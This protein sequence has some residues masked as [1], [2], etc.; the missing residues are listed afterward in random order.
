MAERDRNVAAT[1]D[2]IAAF[3]RGDGEAVA[4]A[5]HPEVETHISER[6]V[7]PGTWHGLAGFG[8]GVGSWTDAWDG[9]H[10]EILEVVAVDDR[11]VLAH[12]HQ[13]ATG[14]GSG[15]PVAMDAV[16]LFEFDDGRARRFHVYPD[17]ESAEAA[18]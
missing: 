1:R 7:N 13:T 15:V 4:A 3:N 18:I 11:N 2:G 6:M 16:L 17:G 12:V 9:L 10:F 5:L 8:E 14:K